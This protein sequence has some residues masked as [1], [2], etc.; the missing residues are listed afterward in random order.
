MNKI[1]LAFGNVT[2]KRIK[3]SNDFVSHMIEHIAW[4]LGCSI[5]LE[6]ESEDWESLGRALG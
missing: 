1:K 5:D 6:W 3:T 4:R 2:S